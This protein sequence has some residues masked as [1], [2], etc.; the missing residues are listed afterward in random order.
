MFSMFMI[1]E[2]WSFLIKKTR[3]GPQGTGSCNEFYFAKTRKMDAPEFVSDQ[4]YTEHHFPTSWWQETG[5]GMGSCDLWQVQIWTWVQLGINVDVGSGS[6]LGL[7]TW[8]CISNRELCEPQIFML[9]L[10]SAIY[11]SNS[12]LSSSKPA[13]WL[14]SWRGMKV[15]LDEI[16]LGDL[17]NPNEHGGRGD[18]LQFAFLASWLP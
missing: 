4:K 6:L 12:V 8:H 17:Q 15:C 18:M 14:N 3:L 7:R 13:D 2:K 16:L 11:V 9:A 5:G 1:W 10:S